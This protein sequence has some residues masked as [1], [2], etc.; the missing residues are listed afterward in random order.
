MVLGGGYGG[1]WGPP[2][3]PSVPALGRLNF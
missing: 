2:F 1:E 3:C